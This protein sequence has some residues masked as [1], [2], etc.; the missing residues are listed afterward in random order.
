MKRN[1]SRISVLMMAFILLLSLLTFND[2]LG[3]TVVEGGTQTQI[4]QA[5]P[6]L[7]LPVKSQQVETLKSAIDQLVEQGKMTEAQ[8]LKFLSYIKEQPG[9][10]PIRMAVEEGVITKKQARALAELLGVGPE[11]NEENLPDE[12]NTDDVNTASSYPIVDTGQTEFYNNSAKTITQETGDLFY[13]QD[14]NY[15]GFQASY[16]DNGDGTITDNVTGLMWEQGFSLCNFDEVQSYAN[17]C[18]TGGYDDWRIPTIKELYSL[19]DFS[20][21]QGTGE[22]SAKTTPEDAV[23]FIDTGYFEFEYPDDGVKR[24]IDAQY[25]SATEYVST[26]MNGTATFFGVNFADGRIKGYPQEPG[27]RGSSGQYYIRLV[28]GDTDYGINLFVDNG[29]GTV[30]DEAT[31]LMWSQVDSGDDG[32]DMSAFT[33]DN[34]SLNWQEALEFA[35][36]AEYAGYDDWRLPNAKELQS[37]LDYARSPDTTNSAAI[38]PVFECSQIFN[39]A[40]Q[41][42]YPFFWTSTSFNPGKDAAILCFGRALGYFSIQGNDAEF[43]DVHGAGCQRTDPKIGSASYGNGPQGDVRRVYNYVR[44]VRDAN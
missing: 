13:G 31:E 41:V 35:E 12:E 30:T 1:G 7:D 5:A 40:S 17:A 39:E 32:F 29:D 37:I 20:G 26:T 42:D 24:Y 23:P 3:I 8:M 27:N 6:K 2:I 43:M 19:I 22:Q 25:I 4:K 9:K 38:D 16:T 11:E 28:R 36:N 10:E 34:G 15:S 14:A 18:T 44:L 21:N 33:N